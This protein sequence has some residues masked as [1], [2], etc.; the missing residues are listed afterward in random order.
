MM[1]SELRE[2]RVGNLEPADLRR[3]LDHLLQGLQHLGIGLAAIRLRLLLAIPQ[4]DS[5]AVLAVRAD[6]GDLIGEAGLL[7]QQ[8]QDVLL[9]RLVELFPLSGLQLGSNMSREHRAL[10]SSIWVGKVDC[11]ALNRSADGVPGG[12][13][14]S[15]AHMI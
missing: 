6:E 4:A 2:G 13:P 11:V 8:G 3:A 15:V 14:D 7:L 1:S 10:P 9:E 12:P 5:D